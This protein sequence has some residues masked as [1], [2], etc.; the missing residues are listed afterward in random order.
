MESQECNSEEV[1]ESPAY[2]DEDGVVL[3]GPEVL[4]EESNLDSA[5][6]PDLIGYAISDVED[7]EDTVAKE[8]TL[9]FLRKALH[10]QTVQ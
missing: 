4:T 9:L 1:V 10:W 8:K 2:V 6:V 5:S 3:G 7:M